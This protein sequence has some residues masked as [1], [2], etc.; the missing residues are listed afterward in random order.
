MSTRA[1]SYTHTRKWK[2]RA[3]VWLDRRQK[4]W[5]VYR[6]S[7]GVSRRTSVRY[8]YFTGRTWGEARGIAVEM[9]AR[10]KTCPAHKL[11][12]FRFTLT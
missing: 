5:T 2:N 1:T 9:A 3:Y 10:L 7:H 6:R 4:R 12:K 8:G 11:A